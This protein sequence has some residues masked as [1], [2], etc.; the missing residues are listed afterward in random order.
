MV[1]WI[2]PLG[3]SRS[4]CFNIRTCFCFSI[5]CALI[6]CMISSICLPL[7][8]L[9][10]HCMAFSTEVYPMAFFSV[11][12]VTDCAGFCMHFCEQVWELLVFKPFFSFSLIIHFLSILPLFFVCLWSPFALIYGF[13]LYFD[14]LAESKYPF[15]LFRLFFTWKDGVHLSF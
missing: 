12:P 13:R 10:T 1:T 11:W 4:I 2:R 7:S 14:S 8:T 5:I 3:L 6:L 9:R 15:S